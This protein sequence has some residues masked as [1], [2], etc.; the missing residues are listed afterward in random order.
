MG[1]GSDMQRDDLLQRLQG[2]DRAVA[3]TY[4]DSLF[5]VVIAGGGAL[6]LLG[7]LS[8]P[9]DDIDALKFPPELAPLMERFDLNG[10]V[11]AYSASG[12]GRKAQRT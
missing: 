8:R 5:E 6:V 3:L 7:V 12:R 11:G 2:F 10:R 9:T 4:P 1:R